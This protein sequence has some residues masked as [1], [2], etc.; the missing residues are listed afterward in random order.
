MRIY[1][2]P[3]VQARQAVTDGMGLFSAI[4]ALAE[5]PRAAS[6]NVSVPAGPPW[7]GG[8][9]LTPIGKPPPLAVRLE[10]ALPFQR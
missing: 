8:I 3:R 1:C 4:C 10:K 6:R 7:L 9:F 5:R 2:L